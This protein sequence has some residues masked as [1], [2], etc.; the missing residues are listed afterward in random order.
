MEH[1][2]EGRQGALF[3]DESH[4]RF[5]SVNLVEVG[6]TPDGRDR[7]HR[8]GHRILRETWRTALDI[9]GYRGELYAES[10]LLLQ[11][12]GAFKHV[13]DPALENAPLAVFKNRNA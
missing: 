6:A 4:N 2:L 10:H 1:V 5:E 7:V 11:L 3:Q 9:A 8:R 13:I 12:R